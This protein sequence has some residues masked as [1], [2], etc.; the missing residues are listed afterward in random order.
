MIRIL[1]AKLFRWVS[2]PRIAI[3]PKVSS[4]TVEATAALEQQQNQA[5]SLMAERRRKP[6]G[7]PY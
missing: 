6:T 5:R 4:P 3:L 7:V 1:R 2:R